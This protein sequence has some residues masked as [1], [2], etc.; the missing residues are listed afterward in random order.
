MLSD[1]LT[2]FE[3]QKYYPTNSNFNCVYSRNNL[4]KM[5]DGVCNKHT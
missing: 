4:P 1:P 3:K 2:N 5:K